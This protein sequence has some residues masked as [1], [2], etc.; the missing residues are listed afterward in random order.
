MSGGN[1]KRR[2][3]QT[4]IDESQDFTNQAV[5]QFD[6]F[7]Q[8]G[9]AAN[10]SLANA[11]GLNGDPNQS[12]QRFEASPFNAVFRNDFARDKDAIDQGLSNQ[13]LAFSG[14]RLEAIENA[15]AKN[16]SQAFSQFQGNLQG[17]S[18]QGFNAAGSQAGLIAQQGTQNLN[19]RIGQ[20]STRQGFLG[21]L[22]QFGNAVSSLPGV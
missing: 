19:A 1:K 3:I 6:P 14:A 13:G 10:A 5:S 8:S 9:S 18:N 12:L 22:A 11:V 20:A 17:L 16:F 2:D 7:A 4:G 15:R 21:G